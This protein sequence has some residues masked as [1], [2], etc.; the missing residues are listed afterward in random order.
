MK[1]AVSP[2]GLLLEAGEAGAVREL[3]VR[4]TMVIKVDVGIRRFGYPVAMRIEIEA[5]CLLKLAL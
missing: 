3:C 4:F 2:Q 1:A 5:N